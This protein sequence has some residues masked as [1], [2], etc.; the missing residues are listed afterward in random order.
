M[1]DNVVNKTFFH[2]KQ[3]FGAAQQTQ[4]IAPESHDPDALQHIVMDDFFTQATTLVG[5]CRRLLAVR[6]RPLFDT[7]SSR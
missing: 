4:V 1:V 2:A 6:Q 7:V 3:G 5:R